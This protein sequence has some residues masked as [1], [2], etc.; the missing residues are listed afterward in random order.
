LFKH[1]CWTGTGELSYI[2]ILTFVPEANRLSNLEKNDLL[3]K[4]STIPT[5]KRADVSACSLI[6]VLESFT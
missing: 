5:I 2:A 4:Y 3:G 1:G 6:F